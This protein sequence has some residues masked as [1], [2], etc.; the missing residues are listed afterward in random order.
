MRVDEPATGA[1]AEYCGVDGAKSGRG[2]GVALRVADPVT[3]GAAR[4]PDP[5]GGIELDPD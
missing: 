3:I 1:G 2:N 4:V 5:A